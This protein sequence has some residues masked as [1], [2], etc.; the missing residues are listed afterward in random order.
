MT[1]VIRPLLRLLVVLRVARSLVLNRPTALLGNQGAILA[2]KHLSDIDH[3]YIG[4]ALRRPVVFVSKT[5]VLK[6]PLAGQFM[7]FMGSITVDRDDPASKAAVPGLLGEVV[8]HDGL[9][10][11]YPEG[12]I[13]R[14]E[15][16]G[17]LKTGV[18]RVALATNKPILLVGIT[19]TDEVLPSGKGAR[20]NIRARVIV[21]FDDK[22]I[23]PIA[24]RK[25]V[26]P[27]N[28]FDPTPE[29]ERRMIAEITQ[30]MH[31]GLTRLVLTA[32]EAAATQAAERAWKKHSHRELARKVRETHQLT[33]A[34][35]R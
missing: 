4:G 31:D 2:P 34:Y 27:E 32:H 18:A 28:P 7:R 15:V 10:I 33:A 22:L 19:G 14:R 6:W 20:P 35:W 8:Q 25:A 12:T 21:H 30:L 9:A 11:M 5:E 13:V 23:D 3:F 17:K 24:V 26:A 16:V 1:R 29:Q